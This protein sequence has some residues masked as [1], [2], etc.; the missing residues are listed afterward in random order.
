M[1][2]MIVS[3]YT[4]HITEDPNNDFSLRASGCHHPL[5]SA[6]AHVRV[7]HANHARQTWVCFGWILDRSDSL[8]ILSSVCRY[9]MVS[10]QIQL[11]DPE[12]SII[13]LNP[14]SKF[15]FVLTVTPS[16][17]SSWT[18]VQ[19]SRHH[20]VRHVDCNED[21]SGC[22]VENQGPHSIPFLASWWQSKVH[23]QLFSKAHNY[24]SVVLVSRT[25]AYTYPN[26]LNRYAIHITCRLAN[27]YRSSQQHIVQ[28]HAGTVSQN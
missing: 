23:W 22:D 21:N 11:H 24:T 19:Q 8:R 12:K 9:L 5:L 28:P 14:C 1:L 16:Y 4:T 20:D 2:V 17:P 7:V 18:L 10:E 6:Q 26:V 13:K 27:M 25:V 3:Q 15:S